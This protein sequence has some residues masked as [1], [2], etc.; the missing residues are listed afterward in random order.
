MIK[1]LFTVSI[2][3]F[4]LNGCSGMSTPVSPLERTPIYNAEYKPD[5]TIFPM[6]SVVVENSNLV[7]YKSPTEEEI[8]ALMVPYMLM[9]V[10]GIIMESAN[11][12]DKT[13]KNVIDLTTLTK[14]N[15]ND[16]VNKEFKTLNAKGELSSKLKWINPLPNKRRYSLK[17]FLYY[18]YNDNK[19][20]ELLVALRVSQLDEEKVAVWS[21]SYIY[22][23]NLTNNNLLKNERQLNSKV[24]TIYK[25]LIKYFQMHLEGEIQKGNNKN[26]N[27]W[28]KDYIAVPGYYANVWIVPT[29]NKAHTLIYT[30]GSPAMNAVMSGIHIYNTKDVTV[31]SVSK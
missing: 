26:V 21:G 15:V 3:G 16:I 22:H 24:K 8:N 19:E 28:V 4:L 11:M 10:N 14:L 13:R 1:I 2:L 7:V 29:N 17:P 25:D 31:K 27:V 20:K 9:G 30:S 12:A 18:V 5:H 6:A 23:I